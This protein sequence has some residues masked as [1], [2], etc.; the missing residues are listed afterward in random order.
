[1]AKDDQG[2]VRSIAPIKPV[3]TVIGRSRVSRMDFF[4]FEI[5]HAGLSRPEGKFH[6][7]CI[8]AFDIFPKIF[9]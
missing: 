7:G 3:L 6:V 1:V 9:R 5:P 8:E 4:E 2:I